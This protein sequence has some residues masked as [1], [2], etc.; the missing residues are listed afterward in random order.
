MGGQSLKW[1][2][3][4][5]EPDQL[6]N[7]SVKANIS[8]YHLQVPNSNNSEQYEGPARSKSLNCITGGFHPYGEMDDLEYNI[9]IGYKQN[10]ILLDDMP[11]AR[12]L[13]SLLLEGDPNL[14]PKA[15]DVLNHPLFWDSTK[16]LFFMRDARDLVFQKPD[17]T[18]DQAIQRVATRIHPVSSH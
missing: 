2:E 5:P 1:S 6:W 11:V 12:D 15:A 18:L 9:E 7:S 3:L 13:V 4:L 10:F 14:K 16:R 17:P 8:V